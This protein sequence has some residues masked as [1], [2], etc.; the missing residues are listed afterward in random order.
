MDTELQE[1][2]HEPRTKGK[3]RTSDPKTADRGD[4]TILDKIRPLSSRVHRQLSG[5][6]DDV[7]SRMASL[8]DTRR[9]HSVSSSS[10]SSLEEVDV[11]DEI[12]KMR[13]IAS[14]GN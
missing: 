7:A 13:R 3:P 5:M 11:S 12:K 14:R 2:C 8:A 10:H 1:R 9:Q 6:F 4:D